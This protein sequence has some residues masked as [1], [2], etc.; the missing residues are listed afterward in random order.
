[1]DNNS[2]SLPTDGQIDRILLDCAA[3]RRLSLDD[4]D[5]LVN[6]IRAMRDKTGSGGSISPR[7]T[8]LANT[9]ETLGSAIPNFDREVN[10]WAP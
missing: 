3:S 2:R 8:E 10:S 7:R 6:Y 1:M 4:L 9:A 5:R